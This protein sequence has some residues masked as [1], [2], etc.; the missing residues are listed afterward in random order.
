MVIQPYQN[1]EISAGLVNGAGPDT[2][3]LRFDRDNDKPTTFFMR[4]DEALAVCY[5]LAGA[6][7]SDEIKRL[8]KKNMK[9]LY[10]DGFDTVS[11]DDPKDADAVFLYAIG[12]KHNTDNPWELVPDDE[13]FTIVFDDELKREFIP[14]GAQMIVDDDGILYQ[15]TASAWANHER[16]QDTIICSTEI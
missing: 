6:M 3:Y 7:W 10:T 14:A 9:H 13:L 16:W 8:V 12:E 5:V 4:P 1:C 2:I 11:A 15:A